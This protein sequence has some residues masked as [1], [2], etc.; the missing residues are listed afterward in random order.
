MQDSKEMRAAVTELVRN[1]VRERKRV[2][3]ISNAD[4]GAELGVSSTYIQHITDPIGHPALRVGIELECAIAEKA[5]GGSV[6]LLRRSALHVY[7]GRRHILAI[8][9]EARELTSEEPGGRAP[10]STPPEV[11]GTAATATSRRRLRR[12]R[13]R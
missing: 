10:S 11:S 8:K 1:Y 6:D 12:A 13:P 9:G 5:Y 4:L 3:D 7:G 2:D